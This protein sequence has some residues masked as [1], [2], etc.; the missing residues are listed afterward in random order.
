[1]GVSKGCS[2]TTFCPRSA[3]TREQ[4]ASFLARSFRLPAAPR[5]YFRDDEE[6]AHENDINRLAAAGISGGC[7][8]VR[9]CPGAAVTREQM[10]SFLARAFQLS[11][12]ETNYFGDDNGSAHES[13]INRLAASGITGGCGAGT[14]CPGTTVTREQM[15]A[16]LYRAFGRR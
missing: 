11:A 2:D 10:A 12:V 6:S 9:F 15:A 3:V 8:A 14:F 5:D 1:M 13:D 16:F 7:A 4:M